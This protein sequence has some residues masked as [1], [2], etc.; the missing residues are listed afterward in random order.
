MID[1]PSITAVWE[2]AGGTVH[3][4][5]G[6]WQKAKCFLHEDKTASASINEDE[7]K[8]RCFA[9][10]LHGD[11][12]DLIG[13]WQH[14]DFVGAKEF[15]KRFESVGVTPPEPCGLLRRSTNRGGKKFVPPWKF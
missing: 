4:M 6:G 1:K 3:G 5:P 14:L 8:Y 13:E 9:C 10:D 12:W 2:A 7:C 11:S 15:G